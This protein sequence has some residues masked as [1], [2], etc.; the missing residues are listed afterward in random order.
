MVGPSGERDVETSGGACI[1]GLCVAGLASSPGRAVSPFNPATL[2]SEQ[3]IGTPV[4]T[5]T[6]T[7]CNFFTNPGLTSATFSYTAS[8]VATAPY[9]GTFTE[10]GTVTVE[11]SS[12]NENAGFSGPITSWD[13]QFR[14][15]SGAGVVE[16]TKSL[17]TG[18]ASTGECT[19]PSGGS[20]LTV[21]FGRATLDYE[22]RIQT[23][24]GL[25][26][27]HG[28]AAT[29][30]ISFGVPPVLA[31]F[32]ETFASA[33]QQPIPLAPGNS[34]LEQPG[35]GCG[36]VHHLHPQDGCKK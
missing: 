26:R 10:R 34:P 3:L 12:V 24:A 1:G 28:T 21:R 29:E 23:A 9:P 2:T 5:S 19:D 22:A 14:I 13:V 15:D 16:G 4:I 30:L 8:G 6:D 7:T 31:T 35:K 20:G 11:T 27:D 33:L 17:D 36:D 18:F 25:F 32:S